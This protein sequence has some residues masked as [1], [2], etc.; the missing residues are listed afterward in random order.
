MFMILPA[1]IWHTS[2]RAA[3]LDRLLR[4]RSKSGYNWTTY[5]PFRNKH[6]AGHEDSWVS[7]LL[8]EFPSYPEESLARALGEVSCRLGKV[9]EDRFD[10]EPFDIHRWQEVNPVTTEALLQLTTGSPSPV[11]N[12]GLPFLRLRYF[13]ADNDRPGLPREVAALV[14]RIEGDCIVVQLL[15][16]SA[17]SDHRLV[18]QA[19]TFGEDQFTSVT[20]DRL[21]EDGTW[22]GS[23]KSYT[24]PKPF[25][26]SVAR[27]LKGSRFGV[28]LTP[29]SKVTLE[30]TVERRANV[31]SL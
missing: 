28:Q 31:P 26:I 7:Y 20:Y 1:T 30:L 23:R 16:T 10:E 11:Y 12:G 29:L 9:R 15:N 27:D 25:A 24:I 6:D 5:R 3:D 14:E 8:G 2:G 19:G 17:V 13:D 4:I 18:V 22:P 21:I